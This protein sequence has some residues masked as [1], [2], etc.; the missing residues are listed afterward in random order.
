MSP[1]ICNVTYSVR[2]N[3]SDE[4]RSQNRHYITTALAQTHY[5]AGEIRRYIHVRYHVAKLNGRIKT[6][7]ERQQYNSRINVIVDVT[8]YEQTNHRYTHANR[9]E[10]F[11]H[12]SN[13]NSFRLYEIIRQTIDNAGHNQHGHIW[14]R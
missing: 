9:I 2:H 11:S 4:C 13:V 7:A 1:K 3:V 6:N 10:E 8:E 12:S 5:G 14:N